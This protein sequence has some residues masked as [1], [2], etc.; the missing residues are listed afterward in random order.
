MRYRP[1]SPTGDFTLGQ[2]FL[3]NTPQAV[4]QAIGTR[5]KLWLAEWFLDTTDGSD[6]DGQVLGERYGKAPDAM[7]KRRILGTTGVSSI[8]SY[9][10]SFS[11]GAAR[12]YNI[13]ALVQTIYSLT[14]ISI[15]ESIQVTAP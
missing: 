2:P 6:W 9:S 11:G 12:T 13:Q 14:P 5:L 8:V 7:V 3:T 1:L 15:N 10:G 4:A